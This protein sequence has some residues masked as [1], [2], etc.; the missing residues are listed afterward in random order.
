MMAL[1]GPMKVIA[2]P[3]V[4]IG[5]LLTVSF[6]VPKDPS[7][8]VVT[9]EA[10]DRHNFKDRLAQIAAPTLV[11]A[12]DKDPFYPERL[13]RETAEGIPNARLI[14]YPGMGHPASGKQ[15]NQDVL[16]FLNEG[17]A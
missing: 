12:G 14:L 7:D 3:V 2:A 1:E 9:I 11:V 13:F 4:W 15:F 16:A 10:E 8:L 17:A 6:G 5:S